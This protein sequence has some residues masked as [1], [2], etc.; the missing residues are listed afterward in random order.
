MSLAAFNMF[1]GAAVGTSVNGHLMN[2]T[3]TSTVFSIAAFVILGVGVLA[4][5]FVS[6]F[7]MRKRIASK[8]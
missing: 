1:L 8:A 4:A 5:V 2:I 7:G 6:G 3:N